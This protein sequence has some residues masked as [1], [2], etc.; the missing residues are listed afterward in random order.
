VASSTLYIN[1]KWQN[2]ERTEESVNPSTGEVLG[3]F[4]VASDKQ[5]RDAV[6]AARTAFSKWSKTPVMDRVKSM[7]AV[8]DSIRSRAG[9]LQELI[10]KE[11]GKPLPESE[12][13]VAETA[14]MITFLAEQTSLALSG[15]VCPVDDVLF[16]GKFNYGLSRPLGVVAA[17]KPWNYPLELSVWSVAAALLAGNTVVLKPS[18]Y[19]PL[20]AQALAECMSSGD[21][22]PGVF[23]LLTGGP[24]VGKHLVL[25]DVDCVAFTGSMETG[26]AISQAVAGRPI[27]LHLELGGKDPFIVC[28]DA[29]LE[30]AARGGVWGAFTNCGQVC[31]SA[32]RFIVTE[33]IAAQFTDLFV[34]Y[35]RTLRVGDPITNAV[36]VGPLVSSRQLAKVEAHVISAVAQGA[37]VLLGGKRAD[38]PNLAKGF[39]YE[40]TILAN[41]TPTMPV[42]VEE[43]FG[44]VAPIA[45]VDDEEAA[46]ALASESRYDLGA[47]LWTS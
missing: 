32:E 1:G 41:V 38:A 37:R 5:V 46:I 42:W 28:S 6:I 14:D 39:F 35:S 12:I 27:K 30:L 19:T 44:P 24:D 29:N 31:V 34:E 45:V 40:P 21:L 7:K 4:G 9:A 8:A 26:K 10:T 11:M 15:E 17:I 23:N 16:P 33:K 25:S 47:S 18:E 2:G 36:D 22:P 20:V 13:E 43:T 3:C